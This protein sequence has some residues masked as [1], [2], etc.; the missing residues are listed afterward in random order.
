MSGWNVIFYV[1]A[2]KDV[3]ASARKAIEDIQ[4][5]L[6]TESSDRCRVA[7][8]LHTATE[9]T[10]YWL[11]SDLVETASV[12]AASQHD[13]LENL[14]GETATRWPK[15]D[16]TALVLLGHGSGL[17][18]IEGGAPVAFSL[19][20]LLIGPDQ[21]GTGLS[22]PDIKRVI[23]QAAPR[24]DVLAF[25][26]CVMGMLEIEWEMAD[27]VDV[28]VAAEIDDDVWPHGAI[29][30]SLMSAPELPSPE[31]LARTIVT[32]AQSVPA[33]N[34]AV[35]ASRSYGLKR[36]ADAVDALAGALLPLLDEHFSAID[37]AIQK[38]PPA[39]G[40]FLDL[41]LLANALG[42]VDATT[43]QP[44]ADVVA[45]LDE[46]VIEKTTRGRGAQLSGVSLLCPIARQI[47]VATAYT[48]LGFDN[49]RWRD[50]LVAYDTK[51]RQMSGSHAAE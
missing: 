27:A 11:T 50:F 49:R 51:G 18:S 19:K 40:V 12:R 5:S 28:V 30:G 44:A 38:A 39:S 46:T 6:R 25:N 16:R 13:M 42:T 36:L 15:A 45:M 20:N 35:A 7:F 1:L 33:P 14:L 4:A 43:R 3:D 23:A 29:I 21:D 22:N 37:D 10:R 48:G 8:E 34:V 2:A 32:Q 41:A 26:A 47:Q 24:I 31:A 17:D 9:R